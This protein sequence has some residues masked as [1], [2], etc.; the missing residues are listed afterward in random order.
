MITQSNEGNIRKSIKWEHLF[1]FFFIPKLYQA[2]FK[3]NKMC[4]NCVKSF[5]NIFSMS[6]AIKLSLKFFNFNFW[7]V[8]LNIY[9]IYILNCL[10]FIIDTKN[11][12]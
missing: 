9:C 6:L 3:Q 4:D 8:K 5:I 7:M 11:M 10:T 1:Y 2:L 12:V